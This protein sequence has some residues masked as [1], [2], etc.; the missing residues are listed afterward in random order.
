MHVCAGWKVDEILRDLENDNLNRFIGICFDGPQMM[1]L[2]KYCARGSLSDVI[3]KDSAMMDGFIVSALLR[4]IMN[5]LHFIHHSFLQYH[6]FLTSKC[7]LTDDRW[8]V[9]ISTYGL[10]EICKFDKISPKVVYLTPIADSSPNGMSLSGSFKSHSCRHYKKSIT[11]A[12]EKHYQKFL[13][14][15][16]SVQ[17]IVT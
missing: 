5:G 1:S 17:N 7:C 11:E 15:T 8:Q 14:I 12:I 2:W 16:Y 3:M 9:K 4:D 10:Q 13:S 6:G